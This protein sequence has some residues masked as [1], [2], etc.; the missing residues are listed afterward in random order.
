MYFAT[1]SAAATTKLMSGSFVLRRGVGTAMLMV[2][3]SEMT[4][5]SVVAHRWPASTCAARRRPERPGY[6][7]RRRWCV[8]FRALDVNAGDGEA[9]AGEFHRQGEAH[10]A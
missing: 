1:C 8:H 10:V 9:S 7:S 3:S 6:R 4:E 2:S 5:K